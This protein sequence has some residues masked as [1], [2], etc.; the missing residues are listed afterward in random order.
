MLWGSGALPSSPKF[1]LLFEL[2]FIHQASGLSLQG[3]LK[4]IWWLLRV[5]S[6]LS[7]GKLNKVILSLH[8]SH[9]FCQ[10]L[11]DTVVFLDLKS[12]VTSFLSCTVQNQA[13]PLH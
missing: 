13:K 5:I 8:I 4:A 2:V 12:S 11:N 1:L 6:H 9:I 3:I 7:V 10:L